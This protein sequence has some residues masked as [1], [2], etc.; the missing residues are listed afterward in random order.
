MK[1][2][3]RPG[4]E[5]SYPQDHYACGPHWFELPRETRDQISE[6]FK[7]SARLWREGH[8]AAQK[9]WADKD[10]KLQNDPV[11]EDPQ[12]TLGGF[13]DAGN[14]RSGECRA[15]GARISWGVTVDGKRIPLDTRP[16]VY[17]V[18]DGVLIRVDHTFV[19]HFATC[20][21]ANEFSASRRTEQQPSKE[22]SL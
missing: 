10:E 22:G 15:C 18:K 4:C 7:K 20:P 13:F 19:S 14:L 12:L 6:G 2:C 17:S 9:F 5:K 1:T 3:N 8:A 21:N 16:P 11:I